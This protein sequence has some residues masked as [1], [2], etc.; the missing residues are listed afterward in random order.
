MSLSSQD[1]YS[2]ISL[3]YQFNNLLGDLLGC[4]E[5]P[6]GELLQLA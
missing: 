5:A 1:F 3:K 4:N 6:Y 2:Q